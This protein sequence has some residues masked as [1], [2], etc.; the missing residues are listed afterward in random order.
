MLA[1][2]DLGNLD[3]NESSPR[4]CAL[5]GGVHSCSAVGGFYFVVTA[6]VAHPDW[7]IGTPIA[8][9][10]LSLFGGLAV[11]TRYILDRR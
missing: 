3:V 11:L 7:T 6:T 10:A 9:V 2:Q 5:L 4:K 1:S 8:A